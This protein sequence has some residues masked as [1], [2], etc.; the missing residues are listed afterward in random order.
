MISKRG[1]A[2]VALMLF[3]VVLFATPVIVTWDWELEDPKVTAFRYQIGGEDDDTWT[4][5]D[6]SVT[7]YE[8]EVS[9]TSQSYTLYLQQSYDGINFSESAVEVAEPTLLTEPQATGLADMDSEGIVEEAKDEVVEDESTKLVVSEKEAVL[10]DGPG[11]AIQVVSRFKTT[12]TLGGG[13]TLRQGSISAVAQP[14]SNKNLEINL[15]V[16]MK[17]LWTVTDTLG[18]GLDAGVAYTPFLD[19]T[20]DW[21]KAVTN[22]FSKFG[23][24]WG[25]FTHTGTFTLAPMMNMQFGKVGLDVGAGG[26]VTYG[27]DFNS[28]RNENHMAGVFA[29]LGMGYQFNNVFSMGLEAKYYFVLTEKDTP[30]F[31]NGQ[32]YLGFSF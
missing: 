22:V 10:S 4:T 5:V 6:T 24:V 14:L 32:A 7:S 31:V 3:S 8:L 27:A 11:D 26:F 1:L 2:L 16:Q 17:N 21:R 23:E 12:I 25:S 9:D 20:Y 19:G 15:G 13:A 29:K 30:G 18:F 28:T